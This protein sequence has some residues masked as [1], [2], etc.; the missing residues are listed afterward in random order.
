M[1]TGCSLSHWDPNVEE[2]EN[3]KEKL[4]IT[5][6]LFP[7]FKAYNPV[8]FIYR[9]G[10]QPGSG[11]ATQIRQMWRPSVSQTRAVKKQTRT[12]RRTLNFCTAMFC[13]Y[14]VPFLY[15]SGWQALFCISIYLFDMYKKN[16]KKTTQGFCDPARIVLFSGWESVWRCI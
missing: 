12:R 7:I 6:D 14:P 16:K 1:D 4:N 10:W 13:F 2:T 11:A 3:V 8:S 15:W 9:S 5:L